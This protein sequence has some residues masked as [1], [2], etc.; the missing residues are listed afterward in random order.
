LTGDNRGAA[1]SISDAVQLDEFYAELL[2]EDKVKKVE[3]LMQKY[4]QVAMVGDGVNDTPAMAAASLGI[5]MG[6][7]GSDAAIETA[8]IALM[9]DDLSKLAWLVKHARST[10]N[11]I[12]QNVA[13]SLIVKAVF[14]GLIFANKSTL[15]MA[16]ASDMGATLVVVSNALRLVRAAAKP[17]TQAVHTP[18]LG[19]AVR[20]ECCPNCP[21]DMI[22]R[23]RIA[24]EDNAAY[25]Y[26]CC[27]DSCKPTVKTEDN[28]DATLNFPANIQQ[29]DCECCIEYYD[30][31]LSLGSSSFLSSATA[32]S[33]NAKASASEGYEEF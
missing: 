9:S 15:W 8:D 23:S 32:S 17:T 29:G 10:L 30:T 22:T 28:G 5:S 16:M 1:K 12:K 6:A 25:S 27:S 4:S 3:E 31:N 26:E 11:I 24:S 20:E 7:A 2:P 14:M 18:E 33:S 13:F 19:L 21:M